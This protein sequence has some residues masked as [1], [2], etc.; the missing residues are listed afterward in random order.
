[1][2]GWTPG[3]LRGEAQLSS[4]PFVIYWLLRMPVSHMIFASLVNGRRA[5]IRDEPSHGEWVFDRTEHLSTSVLRIRPRDHRRAGPMPSR[6]VAA[7]HSS[8]ACGTADGGRAPD[9]RPIGNVHDG[10]RMPTA[11]RGWRWARGWKGG[12]RSK[13]SQAR[14]T[15]SLA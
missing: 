5:S 11:M 8:G 12:W 9:A 10:R 7:L 15:P 6:K 3:V 4:V 2:S 14:H 13:R 1:M